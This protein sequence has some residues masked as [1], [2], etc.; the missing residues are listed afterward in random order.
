MTYDPRQLIA[1]GTYILTDVQS[2]SLPFPGDWT[3]NEKVSIGYLRADLEGDL[4]SIKLTGNIGAQLVFTDQSS[5]GFNSPGG[6]GAVRTAVTS[7]DSYSHFLPSIALNFAFSDAFKVRF[8]A[9]RT[10]AR[11][12]MDQLNASSN[13]SIGNALQGPLNSIFSGERRQS[14]AQALPG[15]WVSILSA[16]YYFDNGKGYVSVAG[17]YKW[18]DDFVNPNAGV[19][20]DFTYL[21]SGPDPGAAR[22]GG[23]D[24][25]PRRRD[26][27][28]QRCQG[29]HPRHRSVDLAALRV[30]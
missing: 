23:F 25:L 18:L 11:P 20:R 26:W 29:L 13:A 2:S 10:L 15:R 24:H 27:A 17:F 4:G 5:S 9:A 19:V 16:E 8:G 21:Q 28:G 22:A 1:D 3:V 14:G 12:R 7:G 6:I 30:R